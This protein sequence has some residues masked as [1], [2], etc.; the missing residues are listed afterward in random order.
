MWLTLWYSRYNGLD[1][2]T[3]NVRLLEY[4]MLFQ[5]DFLADTV[6]DGGN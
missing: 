6:D 2:P 5:L 4:M 3:C 1:V